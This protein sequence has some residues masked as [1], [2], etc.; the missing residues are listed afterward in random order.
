MCDGLPARCVCLASIS[1]PLSNQPASEYRKYLAEGNCLALRYDNKRDF[2]PILLSLLPRYMRALL[3]FASSYMPCTPLGILHTLLRLNSVHLFAIGILSS[4]HHYLR[5]VFIMCYNIFC[6]AAGRFELP[7]QIT[8]SNLQSCHVC[9][10]QHAATIENHR[11]GV[12]SP[13]SQSPLCESPLDYKTSHPLLSRCKP[14]SAV[15]HAWG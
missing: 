13:A 6:L 4:F 8:A 12:K 3:R 15:R 7:R 14:I 10:F 11:G 9:Q 5:S 2:T 1:R